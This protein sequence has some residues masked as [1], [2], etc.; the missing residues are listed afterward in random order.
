MSRIFATPLARRLA[1]E[2][3]LDLAALQGSGPAGRIVKADIEA[4]AAAGPS[5]K[6][7]PFKASPPAA[8]PEVAAAAAVAPI[9]LPHTSM[10]RVIARRMVEAQQTIPHFVL[11]VDCDMDRLLKLREELNLR[12]EGFKLSLND[13][14]IRAVALALK[15]VPRANASWSEEA[16]LLWPNID[17]SVAVALDD[18]LVTPI[19]KGA[20][21]K[22]LAAIAREMAALTARARDGK[23][24]PEEFQG[25]TF[26]LSNLGMYGIKDFAAIVNPP[27]ACILAVG[28]ATPCAV[29]KAGA[30][31]IASVMSA[32]ISCDHRVVDGAVGAQFLAEFKRVVEDP[33]V[34]L[35]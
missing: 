25:G 24:K 11:T 2:A 20:D 34:M 31:A 8:I 21:T 3:G 16:I 12:A 14:L 15:K 33:L 28:A 10:R 26:T 5:R 1:A 17:V 27:Q 22:S 29:V 4:A 35:L 9:V 23:L 19:I 32:T 30:L 6:I 7:L 13:F 18:G